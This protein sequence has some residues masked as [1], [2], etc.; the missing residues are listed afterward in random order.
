M[1]NRILLY[2][3]PGTGAMLFTVIIGIV[4]TLMFAVQKLWIKMK[5]VISGGRAANTSADKMGIVIFS[6]SKRYWN[7][8]RL[9]CDEFEARKT[10]LTYWTASP[11]DPA[12]HE[13]YEYV[14]CK[15]IGEGNRA[16][17]RLNAMSADI[18]LSTTP[19]LD[20]YQWKRS[21]NVSWY[22]HVPHEIGEIT[23]YRMFGIDY[24]DA[25]LLNGE[26]QEK[27]IRRLEEL[28]GLKAKELLVTGA[29][30]MDAL[31]DRLRK[32]EKADMH[33]DIITVLVAPGWGDN[34]ILN[35]YGKRFLKCLKSTG[36]NI[37]IRPHPQ[38]KISDPELLE[39]LQKEF[40]DGEKWKWNFDN[41]NFDALSQAD[42]LVS[43]FSGVIFDFAL[44]FGRPVIYANTHWDRA[45]YDSCWLEAEPWRIRILP[46]LGVE[47]KEKD[48]DNIK[49][50]IDNVLHN[51]DFERGRAAVRN[52]AWKYPGESAG[53]I[54]DYLLEKQKETGGVE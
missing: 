10:K 13:K 30:C 3:D 17:A 18:C 6:D 50:V 38:S 41:D 21:E 5:F 29:L 39:G 54:T 51:E 46:E 28:R 52:T 33:H 26:F 40:P 8:F 22:V 45:P 12:L 25:V 35:H 37:I 32:T 48:F 31:A 1:G 34:S 42:V 15:F 9:I 43:D 49:E 2:I 53:R 11:D 20:V 14:D 23:G 16:F 24:Y 44:I 36:Y 4:T 47:L 27:D 7:I 19:G